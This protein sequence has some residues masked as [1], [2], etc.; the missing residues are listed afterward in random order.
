MWGTA[1]GRWDLGV[2]GEMGRR[3]REVDG[4]ADP[5]RKLGSIYAPCH[6]NRRG[7]RTSS[8]ASC[9]LLQPQQ[10]VRIELV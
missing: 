3:H 7:D 10:Y 4:A 1:V 5:R 9:W 6:W 8:L 2:G